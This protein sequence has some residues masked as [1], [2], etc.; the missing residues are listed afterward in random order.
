MTNEIN[1]PKIIKPDLN[2]QPKNSILQQDILTDNIF[3]NE[4]SKKIIENNL[5][6]SG[7]K[8]Y[9]NNQVNL[10]GQNLS[11]LGISSII[12]ESLLNK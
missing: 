6:K 12:L 5:E 7:N 9:N 10:S 1:I 2:Y 4:L 11:G 8:I 3:D